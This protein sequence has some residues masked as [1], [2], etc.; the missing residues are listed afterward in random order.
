ML[1]VSR[2]LA[3]FWLLAISVSLITAAA[4]LSLG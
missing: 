2:T 4:W 3:D 1:P